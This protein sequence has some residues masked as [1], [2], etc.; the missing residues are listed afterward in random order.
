VSEIRDRAVAARAV[1]DKCVADRLLG[2][3]AQ[4]Q[5]FEALPIRVGAED[6]RSSDAVV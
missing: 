3:I 6:G 2:A 1:V 4:L 5:Q